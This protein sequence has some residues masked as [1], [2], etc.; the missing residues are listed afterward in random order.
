MYTPINMRNSTL[1]NLPDPFY[2]KKH[3]NLLVDIT[4]Y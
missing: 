2:T 1:E 4:V 3:Y